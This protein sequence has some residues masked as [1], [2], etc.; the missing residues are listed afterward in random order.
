MYHFFKIRI[1]VS[2]RQ[3]ALYKTTVALHTHHMRWQATFNEQ[4]ALFMTFVRLSCSPSAVPVPSPGTTV[5]L[6]AYW[7]G[8]IAL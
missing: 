3:V 4:Q 7:G 5:T 2:N 1:F 6:W 8:M